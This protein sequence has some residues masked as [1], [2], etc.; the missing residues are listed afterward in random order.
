MNEEMIDQFS[1]DKGGD[2]LVK[3]YVGVNVLPEDDDDD[4]EEH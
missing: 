1:P 3:S 4:E 2:T